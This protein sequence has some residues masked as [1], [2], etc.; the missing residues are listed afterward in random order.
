MLISAEPIARRQYDL[1]K[2]NAQKYANEWKRLNAQANVEFT[3]SG[4]TTKPITKKIAEILGLHDKMTGAMKNSQAQFA[5]QDDQGN[6]ISR[7]MDKTRQGF[8]KL[9]GAM[10]GGVNFPMPAD[11]RVDPKASGMPQVNPKDMGKLTIGNQAKKGEV[12]GTPDT[13]NQLKDAIAKE[14]RMGIA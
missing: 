12:Y 11:I 10:K 9:M 3:G 4:S 2:K 14:L 5:F 13:L 7:A 8:D 6:P 1:H